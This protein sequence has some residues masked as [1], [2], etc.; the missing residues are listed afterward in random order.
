VPCF[1]N[2]RSINP[3]FRPDHVLAADTDFE[4]HGNES[5]IPK[6]WE[7]L[8]R[9]K[10]LPDVDAAA[11]TR[12]LDAGTPEPD[13]AESSFLPSFQLLQRQHS[14]LCAGVPRG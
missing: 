12:S 10:A 9:V 6:Y 11:T 3:G 4:Q 5:L 2:L 7:L 8:E 14:P 13:G 1:S